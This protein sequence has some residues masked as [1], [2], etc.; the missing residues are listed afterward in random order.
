MVHRES[1]NSQQNG[2]MT[3]ATNRSFKEYVAS[4]FDNEFFASIANDLTL[5]QL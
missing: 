3:M 2:G 1:I 5:N 4:R